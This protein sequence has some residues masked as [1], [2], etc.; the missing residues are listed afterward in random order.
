VS[1]LIG[2]SRPLLL[3]SSP[4]ILSTQGRPLSYFR[5][6]PKEQ[7]REQIRNMTDAELIE[8]GKTVR[9]LA[10]PLT[11]STTPCQWLEQLEWAREEWRRRHPKPG[12]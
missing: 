11:V 7:I 2:T 6:I 5:E 8:F 3:N 1:L 12:E 4:R 10:Y 9:R